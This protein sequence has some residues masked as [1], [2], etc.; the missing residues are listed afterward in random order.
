M[1]KSHKY[2]LAVPLIAVLAIAIVGGRGT[3][4]QLFAQQDPKTQTITLTA[5]T[6][7]TLTLATNTVALGTLTPGTP[8]TA[9]TSL[10]VST[11]SGSGW[12]LQTRRDDATTTL[13]L[14]SDPT[15]DFPD[16]TAWS[17]GTFC[18]TAGNA[19]STPGANLSFRVNQAGTSP[20]GLYCATWWGA[21]D[22]SS[23]LYAGFPS[24]NQQIARNNAFDGS[25]QTVVY[26]FRADAPSTQ[27]GGDYSGTITMT[28]I[29]NP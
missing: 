10:T 14:N 8:I 6:T 12:N 2:D 27:A 7:I 29:V 4:R 9:T 26:G 28:A 19:T 11:N 17:P 1:A 13:D 22:T 15:I 24:G 23:A 18:T 21:N 25:A 5:T 3:W 20:S 16:A